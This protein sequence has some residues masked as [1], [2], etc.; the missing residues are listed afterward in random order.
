MKVKRMRICDRQYEK[1]HRDHADQDESDAYDDQH[2]LIGPCGAATE[3]AEERRLNP[4]NGGSD[5][6]PE[7]DR[8]D[9]NNR[10]EHEAEDAYEDNHCHQLTI[11]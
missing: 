6:S 3:R 4:A 7:D 2:G 1:Y 5:L 10:G 8:E 9:P 11:H